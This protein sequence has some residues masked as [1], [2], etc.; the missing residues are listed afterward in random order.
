M[1]PTGETLRPR[2]LH[3]NFKPT[4]LLHGFLALCRKARLKQAGCRRLVPLSD[5]TPAEVHIEHLSVCARAV[6]FHKHTHTCTKNDHQ[7]TDSSCRMQYPRPVI[8]RSFVQPSSGHV[9][10]KRDAGRIV[11]YTPSLMLAQPCNQS[12][13]LLCEASRYLR[14]L[15]LWEAANPGKT[16][17]APV[18]LTLEQAAVDAAAYA[19]K[20]ATKNDLPELTKALLRLYEQLVTIHKDTSIDARSKAL[21]FVRKVGIKKGAAVWYIQWLQMVCSLM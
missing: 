1:K 16:E 4:Y 14:K 13:N 15:Q 10:L 12:M 6:Q 5:D 2:H 11:G 18:L 8:S 3:P 20:Y 17:G 19:S 9:V 21:A 7:G